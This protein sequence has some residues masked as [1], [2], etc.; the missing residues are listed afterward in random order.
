MAQAGTAGLILAGGQGQ[1][2]GGPKAFAVL[3]DGRS[4][5]AA[6]AATLAEAGARPIVATLPPCCQ[7][8]AVEGARGLRLPAPDLDM[9][10]SLRL[11]LCALLEGASWAAVVVLPVDHPLVRPATVASLAA[12][13][14]TGVAAVRPR[15]DGKHG[16]PIAMARAVAEGIADGRLAGPTLRDVLCTVGAV[17]LP[18]ADGGV[19]AN[20]NTP[21]RLAAALAQSAAQR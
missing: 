9:F 1:R 4:F 8:P 14:G 20:C 10:A 7:E 5:L 19:T 6:C 15:H 3:P 11:G 18:V 12:A 16:H 2:F 17:D 13:V 21:E